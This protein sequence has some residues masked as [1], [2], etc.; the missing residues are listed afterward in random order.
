MAS[1]GCSHGDPPSQRTPRFGPSSFSGINSVMSTRFFCHDDSLKPRHC[2]T[3]QVRGVSATPHFKM[4]LASILLLPTPQ[5][6]QSM[7]QHHRLVPVGR[8][9]AYLDGKNQ[10][11]V[12]PA[13]GNRER[14]AASVVRSVAHL[15]SK[16]YETSESP[17]LGPGTG[18]KTRNLCEPLQSVVVR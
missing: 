14:R 8:H 18:V 12:L 3:N 7:D 10:N 2:R 9:T 16:R 17:F 15:N 5:S 6:V 11:T 13:P 1:A 4:P